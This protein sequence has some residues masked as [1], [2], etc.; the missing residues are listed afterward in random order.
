MS[1]HL[2]QPFPTKVPSDCVFF[3]LFYLKVVV[4]SGKPLSFPL[5]LESLQKVFPNDKKVPEKGPTGI[6]QHLYLVRRSV[7][8]TEQ[9]IRQ[10]CAETRAAPLEIVTDRNEA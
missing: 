2:E 4:S 5:C 9:S 6:Q 7:M 8:A 1:Q 3:S 10:H